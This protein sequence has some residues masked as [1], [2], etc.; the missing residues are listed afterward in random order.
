MVLFDHSLSVQGLNL[1]RFG[2]QILLNFIANNLG[3][4]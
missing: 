3:Q 4:H 2:K 1:P